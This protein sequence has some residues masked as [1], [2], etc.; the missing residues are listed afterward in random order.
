MWPTRASGKS[1]STPSVMLRPARRIGTSVTGRL[2]SRHSISS[3]GVVTR[4][5]RVSKRRET[6]YVIRPAISLRRRRKSAG[7]V[8]RSRTIESLCWISG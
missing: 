3:S 2:S 1:C 4:T 6:S 7:P 5:G 8:A